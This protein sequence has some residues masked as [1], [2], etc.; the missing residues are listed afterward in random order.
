MKKLAL[1]LLSLSFAALVYSV[2]YARAAEVE[3]SQ[4]E[5]ALTVEKQTADVA[6]AKLNRVRSIV[7]GA[8][9]KANELDSELIEMFDILREAQDRRTIRITTVRALRGTIASTGTPMNQ[10]TAPT[11]VPSLVVVPLEI[12]FTIIDHMQF[13]ALILAIQNRAVSFAD[14]KIDLDGAQG[15]SGSLRLGI[16]AKADNSGIAA[17]PVAGPP[18]I[19]APRPAIPQV[20]Q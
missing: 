8:P 14:V 12:T 18:G 7:Q 17:Q 3:R 20:A 16:F 19:G 6:S 10:L 4:K 13:E 5:A 15:V 9:T 1:L 2:R 11:D